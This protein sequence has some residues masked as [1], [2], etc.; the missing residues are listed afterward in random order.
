MVKN[1]QVNSSKN[2]KINKST[3]HRITFQLKK[4]L[5]FDISSLFIN[6]IYSGQIAV[7]NKNFL[8]HSYSTDILTFN[9]SGNHDILDGEIFISIEDA[10]DNAKKFK[11]SFSDEIIRLVIH[12]ILHLLGYDDQN[13]KDKIVMKKL[14]NKL[15]SDYKTVFQIN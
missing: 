7:I 5:K 12:G 13:I 1:L 3:I 9:Y 14:E 2:I 6:F 15:S 8:N 10:K 11:V 4:D